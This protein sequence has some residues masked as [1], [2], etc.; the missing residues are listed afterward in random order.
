MKWDMISSSVQGRGHIREGIPCQDKTASVCL[1]DCHVIAL[2]D[3]AGSACLSHEGAACAARVMCDCLSRD[4]DRFFATQNAAEVRVEL[5]EL[6]QKEL[7][8]LADQFGAR[9]Q[10]FA[11]TLLLAAVKDDRYILLHL[12]DG[13]IAYRKQGEILPASLPSNGEYV[14][15]TTFT[16]STQAFYSMRMLKGYLGEIEGFVL[17]SDGCCASLFDREKQRP[18]PVLGWL[19]DLCTFLPPEVVESGLTESLETEVCSA[20]DDDCSIALLVRRPSEDAAPSARLAFLEKV[21]GLAAAEPQ[22]RRRLRVYL[23]V[24]AALERP[25]HL[26]SIVPLVHRKRA[27]LLKKIRFLQDAQLVDRLPDG[28]YVS[29]MRL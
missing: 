19:M 13:L 29:L 16:T 6:L 24:L 17:L 9:L 18:A 2:A 14:N 5:L 23:L 27:H 12:G 11:S 4:F 3:G 21:S 25:G 1:D 22:I 8:A 26:Q 15:S 28:R 20:T 7:C 10:D